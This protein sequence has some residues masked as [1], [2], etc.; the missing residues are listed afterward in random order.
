MVAMNAP[1]DIPALQSLL[2]RTHTDLEAL[3]LSDN[4][5]WVVAYSGGKDST[6]VLQLV[7]NML[8]RLGPEAK[9]PVFVLSS[10]TRVEAPNVAAYVKKSLESIQDAALKQGLPI[11]V[12]LEHPKPEESYWGK[13]IGKG[14]PPPSRWFRWCTSNMKIKPSRRAIDEISLRYGSVIL[15]L[16]TRY[17]ESIQRGRTMHAREVNSRGLNPH[18]EIPNALVA[19]PIAS[20][21]TD[22]V[23]EYLVQ[24][25]CPWGADHQFLLSLYRQANGGECPI[26]LDL[27]TPSCGGS[28]FGCWTCT[29]VKEDKS[30]QGFVDSGVTEFLPLME[31]RNWLVELRD[32]PG[33]RSNV[34]RDN[35]FGHGPFLPSARQE[36]LD[37]LLALELE[38]GFP[39]ITDDELSAIQ[40][41]WQREFDYSGIGV[42]IAKKYG[43]SIV[44]GENKS[45][46]DE[47]ELLEQ[48]ALRH[49]TPPELLQALLDLRRREWPSLDKW[50][51]KAGLERAVGALI[52]K[53]TKQAEAATDTEPR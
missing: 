38:V 17:T 45:A 7:I 4:R 13:L 39:L 35:S 53:A 25:P 30:M 22:E 21:T 6:L 11:T 24:V 14:Y 15:L 19:T 10:D 32:K 29:V 3:Y 12:R 5:P 16:G 9:K 43:R 47:S 41:E 44:V 20:W 52:E 46:V 27:N 18:H 48:A 2:S 8:Q 26:V 23:W 37:R 31:F 34:K 28:R 50:G 40:T 42:K 33:Y 51:A 1:N 49:D 36:I